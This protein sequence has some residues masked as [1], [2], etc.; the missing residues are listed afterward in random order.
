MMAI[1]VCLNYSTVAFTN[2]EN[3]L[4]IFVGSLV[5]III[6]LVVVRLAKLSRFIQVYND[7]S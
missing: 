1:T 3:Y 2:F 6:V 4:N 5:G 7:Q